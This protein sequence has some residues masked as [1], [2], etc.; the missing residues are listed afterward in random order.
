MRNNET[1]EFE[2]V[3]GNRQLLSGF[4]IVVLLFA[5]AFAMGYVVGENSRSAKAQTE[6][7][8][9]AANPAAPAEMRPQPASAA[10]ANPPAATPAQ[11]ADSGQPSTVDSTPQ[12]TTQPAREVPPPT[13]EGPPAAREVPPPAREAPRPAREV[14]PAATAEAEPPAEAPPGS[15]WQVLATANQDSA[16]NVLQSLKDKGFPVSLGPGPNN[17]TRVLVGPYRDTAA[18]GRAKTDLESAGFHPVRR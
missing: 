13:R 14:K 17:L 15:Y 4:F 6:A 9:T 3:V 18:L 8:G 7:P 11:P 12:P 5:V 10:P 2:L 16:Q 1:G